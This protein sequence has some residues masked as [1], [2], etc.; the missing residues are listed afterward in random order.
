MAMHVEMH[1]DRTALEAGV[2]EIRRSPKDGGRVEMICRRPSVEEREVVQE[3]VLDT[4]QGLVGDCWKARGSRS[5]PDGAANPEAQLT[6]TNVR[7]MALVAATP[8]RRQLAGDQ[9]FVDLDLGL[10]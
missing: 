9:L 5:M 6:L 4:E 3:A 2:D 8:E 7:S 10:E 1:L